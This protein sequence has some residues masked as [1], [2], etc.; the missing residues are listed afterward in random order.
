MYIFCFFFFFAAWL[1]FF[2]FI[3]ERS[4]S[5]FFLACGVFFRFG[6]FFFLKI[7]IENNQEN[8][9]KKKKL[10]YFTYKMDWYCTNVN[11]EQIGPIDLNELV[12]LFKSLKIDKQC[13]RWNENMSDWQIIQDTPELMKELQS[14]P[15]PIKKSAPL[16]PAKKPVQ[17]YNQQNKVTT[18]N[19][20]N[21]NIDNAWKEMKTAD[22]GVYYFNTISEQATLDKPKVLQTA[23]DQERDG[24][25]YWLPDDEAAFIP[26]KKIGSSGNKIR[27]EKET[28]S[29]E[30]LKIS[31]CKD[32]NDYIGTIT[33]KLMI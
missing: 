29:I 5:C 23:A 15:K 30:T 16:P 26:A 12:S 1:L 33:K 3:K 20:H 17:S 25:W 22:G 31:E 21:G 27:F 24:E 18:T 6:F 28:G 32:L 7:E 11:D 9:K 10:I 2:K 8:K 4:L 14:K 13:L 19:N